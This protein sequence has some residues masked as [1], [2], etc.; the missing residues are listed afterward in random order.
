M[1]AHKDHYKTSGDEVLIGRNGVYTGW[2][3]KWDIVGYATGTRNA[4]A[5]LHSI[6]ELGTETIFESADGTRYK[7]FSGGEKVLNA[8]ASD[9]LYNFANSGGRIFEKILQG[10]S[11]TGFF[12][13]IS[14]SV[15]NNEI[16]MGDIIVQGNADKQTISEIRREQRS[17]IDMVLKKFNQLNR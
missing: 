3:N 6:D 11:G 10:F 4:T 14:P 5:G 8:K 2:I 16:R 15:V 17:A 9:F 13:K 7:M 1:C 12:D